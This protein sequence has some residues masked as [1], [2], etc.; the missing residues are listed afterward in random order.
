M[1]KKKD[2]SKEIYKKFYNSHG[3]ILQI[4]L[5]DCSMLE[6]FFVGVYRGD[7]ESGEP[8][9]I[10]WHF[11]PESDREKYDSILMGKKKNK[12]ERIIRQEEIVKVQFKAPI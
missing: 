1:M 4:F 5:K 7:I 8:Y 10:K 9:I 6:G 2:Y 12:L 11:V 3:R